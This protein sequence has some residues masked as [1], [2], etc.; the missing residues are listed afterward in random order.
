MARGK[1]DK[2][3]MAVVEDFAEAVDT[4]DGIE[5]PEAIDLEFMGSRED[6]ATTRTVASRERI[7]RQMEEDIQAFLGKGGAIQHIAP[8]VLAD[9]PRKPST[10]YGSRPI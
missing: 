9:P 7:R 10:A 3:K 4:D 1:R 6:T 2:V 5:A 8:N